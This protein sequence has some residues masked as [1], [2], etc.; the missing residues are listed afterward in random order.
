MDVEE[1]YKLVKTRFS[2]FLNTHLH[3]YLQTNGIT[4][5]VFTGKSTTFLVLEFSHYYLVIFVFKRT[6]I[7]IKLSFCMRAEKRSDYKIYYTQLNLT[8]HV[9][10]YNMLK[11]YYG[12]NYIS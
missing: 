11:Y 6:A 12:E 5:L 2:A 10:Y 9:T 4:D 8:F 3:L 1:D 7:C